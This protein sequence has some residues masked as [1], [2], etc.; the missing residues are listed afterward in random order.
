MPRADAAPQGV[1]AYDLAGRVGYAVYH[2]D[3]DE[4]RFGHV[5]LLPTTT[6]GSIGPAC[7]MLF[8]HLA[9]VNEM[10]PLRAIGYEGF[11]APT[12][13]DKDKEK[14]FKTNPAT[15]KKLIGTIATVEMV[16]AMLSDYEGKT[17]GRIVDLHT[18]N[19]ASWRKYWLGSQKRGTPRARWKELSIKKANGLGWEVPGDDAADAL[20]QLHFLLHKLGIKT[21]YGRN[22]S[23]EFINMALGCGMPVNV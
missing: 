13:T 4:P 22:P 10:W 15:L 14:G 20:G 8:D 23:R 1:V 7:A 19:N 2:P 16:A 21:R 12:G 17:H 3:L 11:L 5:D 6:S 18:I 9:W